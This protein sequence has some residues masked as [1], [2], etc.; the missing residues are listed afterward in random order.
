MNTNVLLG[1]D[2]GLARIGVAVASPVAGH[3][4]ALTTVRGRPAPDWAAIERLLDEWRPAALVVGVPTHMDGTAFHMTGAARAF[5]AELATRFALPVH[6][7]DERLSSREAHGRLRDARRSGERRRR[8]R[9]GE[10]DSL[11][12]QVILQAWMEQHA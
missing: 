2:F 9:K 1:F 3:A 7:A 10:T 6:E 8:V 5:M 11:A 12:A 4:S